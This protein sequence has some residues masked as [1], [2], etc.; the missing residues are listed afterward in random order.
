[1][2]KPFSSS[3][4]SI[5]IVAALL[6]LGAVDLRGSTARADDC[7]TA[8]G[9][10]SP[11]GSHWFYHLDST[12]Q[13]KCWY[14]RAAD[15]PARPASAQIPNPP[16][17]TATAPDA[18]KSIDNGVGIPLPHIKTLSVTPWP[19]PAETTDQPVEQ[20][21]QEG[22]A[23][24]STATASPPQAS[25]SMETTPQ[26][27][28][29]Q[30][31]VRPD[32][33]ADGK[34]KS[35]KPTAAL[36]VART[37]SELPTGD[38]RAS[39]NGETG[40]PAGIA[41]TVGTAVSPTTPAEFF[42]I[43]ALGLVVAGILFRVLM[44]IGATRR[45]RVIIDRPK[46]YWKDDQQEHGWRDN[47]KHYA[48]IAEQDVLIDDLNSSLILSASNYRP[49][50]PFQTSDQWPEKTIGKDR[51]SAANDE[52][53]ERTD[54]LEQLCKDLDRMLRSPRGRECVLG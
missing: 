33:A 31:A 41:N 3:I 13:R 35:H 38:I 45:R 4:G 11:N 34:V 44:K 37:D 26:A 23:A 36:G 49:R 43:L 6:L 42:P 18:Q 15:Q 28:G 17:N 27:A 30:P 22:N 21:A 53:S 50:R 32:P 16:H 25:T 9:S 47:Q 48:A 10:P 12:K 19:A 40:L 39:N 24:S 8:P 5:A 14:L 29:P 52:N 51:A 54:T 7:L 46:S 1:M 20:S 2:P